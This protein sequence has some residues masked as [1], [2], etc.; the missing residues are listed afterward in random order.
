[1]YEVWA[2]VGAEGRGAADVSGVRER[3]LGQGA[4]KQ[5]AA[6]VSAEAAY[7]QAHAVVGGAAGPGSVSQAALAPA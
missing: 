1:M 5:E 7:R 6:G 4:G 3:V 2:Q